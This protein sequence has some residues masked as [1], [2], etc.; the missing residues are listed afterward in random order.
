MN[1]TAL[2]ARKSNYP[3]GLMEWRLIHVKNQITGHQ[4]RH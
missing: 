2:G 4:K 1:I 3:H